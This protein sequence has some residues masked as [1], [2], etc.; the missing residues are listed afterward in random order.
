MR[1][2][3]LEDDVKER[4]PI[5]RKKLIGHEIVHAET[6]N[7][8]ILA[9]QDTAFDLIF[10]DHDLGGEQMVATSNKNTGSEVVRWMRTYLLN[11][12]PVIVHSY[13]VGA[14]I[15]MRD[16]LQDLG[17]DAYYIPFGDLVLRLDEPGF[18]TQ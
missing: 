12:C 13:N 15:K 18:I 8:A 4:M 3:I 7:E 9:M 2:L 11:Y 17:M 6:A 14:A 5:F 16:D 1:I 10:L